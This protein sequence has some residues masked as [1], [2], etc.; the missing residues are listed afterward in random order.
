MVRGAWCG[1][2]IIYFNFNIISIHSGFLALM[3]G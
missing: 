2:F 3:A 1:F